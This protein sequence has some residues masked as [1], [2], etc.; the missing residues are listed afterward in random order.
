MRNVSCTVEYYLK[1]S[2]KG[3][4]PSKEAC[5]D[6]WSQERV[7]AITTASKVHFAI[8]LADSDGGEEEGFY[9]PFANL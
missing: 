6:N 4:V 5:K 9:K 7:K 3:N 1:R 2:L 8:N